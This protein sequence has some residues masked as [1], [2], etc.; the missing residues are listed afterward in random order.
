MRHAA[1]RRGPGR[2][3]IVEGVEHARVPRASGR[4]V[5]VERDA[6]VGVGAGTS[7]VAR[8]YGDAAPEALVVVAGRQGLCV[9]VP[10]RLHPSASDDLAA[11]NL[12][13]VREVASDDDLEIEARGGH[14]VVSKVD[15][16]VN[17][18]VDGAA[19]GQTQG[20]GGYRPFLRLDL[21]VAQDRA[22]SVVIHRTRVKQLEGRAVGEDL[23]EADHAG[24][25]EEQA[26]VGIG[27]DLTVGLAGKHRVSLVHRDKRRSYRDFKWHVRWRL[28]IDPG[29]PRTRGRYPKS[30]RP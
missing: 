22:G 10:F 25:K 13:Q 26:F 1:I 29:E 28:S 12:E 27:Q 8:L 11:L 30:G 7:V 6:T 18:A 15:I 14:P 17:P 3:V 20:L 21:V 19:Q 9:T 23:I 4:E 24:V 5:D 2:V 16:L